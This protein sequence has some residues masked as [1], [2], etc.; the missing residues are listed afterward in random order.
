M[1]RALSSGRLPEERPNYE[2]FAELLAS[3]SLVTVRPNL[4]WILVSSSTVKVEADGPRCGE[5]YKADGEQLEP[6][7]YP[8]L[9]LNMK[10]QDWPEH[11]RIIRGTLLQEYT[12]SL[13]QKESTSVKEL[14]QEWEENFPELYE[15]FDHIIQENLHDIFHFHVTLEVQEPDRFPD[16][17]EL[18]SLVEVTIEQAALQNHNWRSTTR[19]SRPWE[20]TR[21]DTTDPPLVEVT[22]DIGILYKHRPGC[23]S[24]APCDCLHAAR[25]RRQQLAVPFP[26]TEWAIMLSHLAAYPKH[27]LEDKSK[28]RSQYESGDS[29]AAADE[30]AG[31]QLDLVNKI[32]MFQE[33]WSCAPD[34]KTWTRRAAICWTFATIH[35]IDDRG[36]KGPKVLV[37]TPG[38]VWRFLTVVDPGS[39]LHRQQALVR[40]P[41]GPAQPPVNRD[42][43]TSPHPGFQ[44]QLSAAMSEN[45]AAAWDAAPPALTLSTAAAALPAVSMPSPYAMPPSSGLSVLDMFPH[46]LAT[47]PPT[48]SL[49]SAYPGAFEHA[50]SVSHHHHHDIGDAAHLSF[51]SAPS[52]ADGA[53]ASA[54]PPL[55][56]PPRPPPP[57]ARTSRQPRWA[58]PTSRTPRPAT[59]ATCRPSSTPRPCT[60][61]TRASRAG[62]PRSRLSAP[63]RTRP[64]AACW[65][66]ATKSL[67]PPP[68]LLPPSGRPAVAAVSGVRPRPRPRRRRAG[69][70]GEA[71]GVAALL[72]PGGCPAREG[73]RC[74]TRLRLLL[75]AACL[76]GPGIGRRPSSAT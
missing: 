18:N 10:R 73:R 58:S 55:P 69:T 20:L 61:L 22:Q 72:P 63:R 37:S 8:H 2:Y 35:S 48:A 15:S 36:S 24:P 16:G 1:L 25:V 29:K 51:M 45:F 41:P 40:A 47:P 5:A 59:A 3:D 60:P 23:E 14:A 42:A 70:V 21:G 4:C 75:L 46:G 7:K 56:A 26:A 30:T 66:G 74:G 19:L 49:Q 31:T 39:Q 6:E 76:H 17:S 33:L 13:T 9:H 52:D 34:S 27:P 38:T 54:P 71:V 28:T 50:V 43:V 11:G 53:S 57:R 67:P 65:P 68:R 12:R 32:A 64:A 62:P 44:Q